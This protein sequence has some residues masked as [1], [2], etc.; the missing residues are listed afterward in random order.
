MGGFMS[1]TPVQQVQPAPVSKIPGLDALGQQLI[2]QFM[3]MLSGQQRQ[4][5]YSG[6]Q[7]VYGGPGGSFPGLYQQQPTSPAPTQP[8]P[9]NSGLGNLGNISDPNNPIIAQLRQAMGLGN[10]GNVAGG[11]RER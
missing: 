3:Q 6:F 8:Q 10:F 7:S 2:Q 9:Q 5:P 11:G 1:S 4:M